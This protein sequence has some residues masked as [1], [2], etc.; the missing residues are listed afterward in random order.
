[1]VGQ[2]DSCLPG[3]EGP[4]RQHDPQPPEGLQ[5]WIAVAHATE[6]RQLIALFR[7]SRVVSP[8]STAVKVSGSWSHVAGSLRSPVAAAI[9]CEFLPRGSQTTAPHTPDRPRG[10]ANVLRT[11]QPESY[12]EISDELL[13][14]IAQDSEELELAQSPGV[15][16]FRR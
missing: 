15:V 3:Q 6:E 2:Q 14:A 4:R 13:A 8:S 5:I 9:G 1:M 12:P 11:G 10:V 16:S 7:R